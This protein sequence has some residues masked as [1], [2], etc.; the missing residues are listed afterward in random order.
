M[1]RGQKPPDS[2]SQHSGQGGPVIR[3]LKRIQ[4]LGPREC[5][6]AL[7]GRTGPSCSRQPRQGTPLTLWVAAWL[8][9]RQPVFAS[10]STSPPG[11]AVRGEGV[12]GTQ[13]QINSTLPPRACVYTH[14]SLLGPQLVPHSSFPYSFVHLDQ[15][16]WQVRCH[17]PHISG[18]GQFPPE[19]CKVSLRSLWPWASNCLL[20]ESG[21]FREPKGGRLRNGPFRATEGGSPRPAQGPRST[22]LLMVFLLPGLHF[23]KGLGALR[24]Q[25]RVA[26]PA[27]WS[28][29]RLPGAIFPELVSLQCRW[30]VSCPLEPIPGVTPRLEVLSPVGSGGGGWGG[31][32]RSPQARAADRARTPGLHLHYLTLS[33]IR[34][35]TGV[36][37]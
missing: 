4:A 9:L 17:G 14:P 10:L 30:R 5:P 33:T 22:L 12:W 15:G 34:H 31:G 18:E 1:G 29:G 25:S 8:S 24:G 28:L 23:P 13:G 2:G 6:S 7:P 16:I 35:L 32:N 20:C 37:E 11:L 26:W 3:H 36:T 21:G 27:G 19:P